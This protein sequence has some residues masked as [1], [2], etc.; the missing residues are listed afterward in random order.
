MDR[1]GIRVQ[2]Y[3]PHIFHSKNL[4]VVEWIRRFG[5]FV[6]WTPKVR[7]K[8]PSGQHVPMP[9][10]LDTVNAV[11]GTQFETA[12]EVHAYLKRIALPVA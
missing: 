1:N 2:A 6:A 8:L 10:N 7:G 5:E 4:K 3:G 11:F 9:I 12:G